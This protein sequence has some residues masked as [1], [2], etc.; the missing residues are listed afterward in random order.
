MAESEGKTFHA[1]LLCEACGCC[2][3]FVVRRSEGTFLLTPKC[4][5]TIDR[6]VLEGADLVVETGRVKERYKVVGFEP[7]ALAEAINIRV[8]RVEEG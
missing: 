3:V 7:S 5:E 1:E 2:K 8:E 4:G 6:C